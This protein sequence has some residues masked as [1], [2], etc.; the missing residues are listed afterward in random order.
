[1][2][3][4]INESKAYIQQF[5]PGRPAVGI[6]LG[7]GLGNLAGE[8]TDRVEIPYD[9]IPHFPPATVEGHSGRLI[10]GKLAGKPVVAMAGRY[11]YYEG[12]SMQQVTFPVRVMKALGIETLLISNAAGGMNAKFRVGDLMILTDHI[13]LQPEHPLRGPNNAALGPRFPDMSEPYSKALIAK[14]KEIAAGKGIHLHEG[15]YVGVQGPTFETRAEYKF[16]HIIGGDAVGMSTVPEVIVAAHSGLRVFA[17]S[18]I[19]DLGIREEEN[20]ITH[21]EVLA[22]AKAAEPHLTYIFS[23]LA[24]QL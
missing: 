10:L 14:A 4:Q 19:T 8:I 17:M 24:R 15:V 2:L 21:E 13:N 6:I 7:S 12:L 22:A 11:H 23:E 5:A 1:M 18:V 16:M 3:E 9:Q 20:V